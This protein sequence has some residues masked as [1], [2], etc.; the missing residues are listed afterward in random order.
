M[1]K[2]I[3]NSSDLK[4]IFDRLAK[5]TH[6]K[7]GLWGKMNVRQMLR[8]LSDAANFAF[9][10]PNP[11]AK[12]KSFMLWMILNI[13]APKN[14]KTY[15][16]LNMVN[17]GIDPVEFENERQRVKD[18][19]AKISSSSGPFHVNPFLGKLSKSEW[20]RLCFVHANHHLKQFGV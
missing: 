2:S 3:N 12:R 8:H 11:E 1:K 16:D 18:L 6:E 19:F 17:K 4:E 5:L 15:P 10:T 13:P 14:V 9:E 20:G 7:K